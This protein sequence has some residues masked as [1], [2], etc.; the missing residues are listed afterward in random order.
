MIEKAR[1]GA[2]MPREKPHRGARRREARGS[3]PDDRVRDREADALRA[4]VRALARDAAR[5]SF[6]RALAEQERGKLEE[7]E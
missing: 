6:E 3:G 5:E 1:I 7:T 4:I 2:I